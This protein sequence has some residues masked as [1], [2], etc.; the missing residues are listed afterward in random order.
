[1]N[2]GALLTQ[3]IFDTWGTKAVDKFGEGFLTN[4]NAEASNRAQEI[5]SSIKTIEQEQQKILEAAYSEEEANAFIL[6][7]KTFH[8]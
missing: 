4:F 3:A 1:M 5:I 2:N 6:G 8:D 7:Y